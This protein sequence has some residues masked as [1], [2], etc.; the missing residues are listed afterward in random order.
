[1]LGNLSKYC[2]GKRVE[3][4]KY[5]SQLGFGG[6]A[7]DG[8]AQSGGYVTKQR[9]ATRVQKKKKSRKVRKTQKKRKQGRAT[10]K[11]RK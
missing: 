1:M 11:N 6:S 2:S 8:K 9:K 5:L 3:I 10:R 4:S 7:P